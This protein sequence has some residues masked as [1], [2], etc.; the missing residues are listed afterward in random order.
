MFFVMV[1]GVTAFICTA[2]IFIMIAL[3]FSDLL[4]AYLNS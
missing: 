3:L 4:D 1:T 2:I